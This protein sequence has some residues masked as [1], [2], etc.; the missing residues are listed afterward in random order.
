MLRAGSRTPRCTKLRTVAGA[1]LFAGCAAGLAGGCGFH[2]MY[3]ER[4]SQATPVA[5]DLAGV[6]VSPIPDR[7][8]Q[9]LRNELERL[10]DPGAEDVAGRYTL[11]VQL[12]ETVDTFAVERTG[13]ATR[14]NVELT[15]RYTLLEDTS[16]APVLAGTSRAVSGFNLLDNDFSTYV[17]GGDARSRAVTVIAYEIRNRLAVHFAKSATSSAG[18]T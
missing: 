18:G 6:R 5:V 16:G 10:L 9:L 17:A 7:S 1:L 13:F 15:A 4:T 12:D 11:S 14:A 2:P 8:G 3:G